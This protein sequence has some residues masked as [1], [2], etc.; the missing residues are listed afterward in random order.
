MGFTNTTSATPN[1]ATELE[2]VGGFTVKTEAGF[3]VVTAQKAG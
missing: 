3:F 1:T 2:V